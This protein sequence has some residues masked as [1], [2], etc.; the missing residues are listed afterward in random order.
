M[1]LTRDQIRLIQNH[2][3]GWEQ[4]WGELARDLIGADGQSGTLCRVVHHLKIS[5]PDEA[6]RDDF[7]AEI[8]SKYHERA[9]KGTLLSGYQPEKGAPENYL[10]SPTILYRRALDFL[11]KISVHIVYLPSEAVAEVVSKEPNVHGNFAALVAMTCQELGPSSLRIDGKITGVIEQA[12]LQLYRRLKWEKQGLARLRDHL[13][14]VICTHDDEP[15]PFA[16]LIRV[17]EAERLYWNGKVDE[18]AEKTYNNGRFVGP[19]EQEKLENQ[20][21]DAVFQLEFMPLR[22]PAV[23]NLLSITIG[24]ANMGRHHYK[25][26]LP[27]LICSIAAFCELDGDDGVDPPSF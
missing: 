12:G 27:K 19:K 25:C 20:W 2:E 22:T 14:A 9:Q 8:M 11:A 15:N 1:T 4:A 17:H 26:Q 23:A 18:I 10:S 24:A 5:W 7:I 21:I 16:V 3:P 13:A 6:T